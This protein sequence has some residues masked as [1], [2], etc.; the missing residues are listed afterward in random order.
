MEKPANLLR[1][2]DL[3]FGGRFR[4]AI[5]ALTPAAGDFRW[6]ADAL[7][8]IG[9]AHLSLND[10][11]SA[12]AALWDSLQREPSN[13]G[14]VFYLGLIAERRGRQQEAAGRYRE[15]LALAP[16]HEPAR[17][18]LAV[19]RQGG[20]RPSMVPL[21]AEAPPA[22]PIATRPASAGLPAPPPGEVERLLDSVRLSVR[23]R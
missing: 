3:I 4:D 16:D 21:P 12:E 13:A 20:G 8:G 10:D 5:I 18:R 23:P 6:A 9:V 2:W 22:P 1:G 15:T 19:L 17:A 7:Y 11:V 14:A